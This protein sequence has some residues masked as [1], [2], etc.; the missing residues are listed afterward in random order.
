MRTPADLA[1]RFRAQGLK[2]TPQRELLFKLVYGNQTH[3][4]AEVIYAE[5]RQVMPTM[6]LK[7]VYQTLNDLTEMGELLQLDFGTG[8]SR[9]DPNIGDHHHLVCTSCGKVRDLS[10]TFAD[11]DV[12]PGDRQGFEVEE[13]EVVFRG[14][15]AAC[16]STAVPTS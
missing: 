1:K 11:L 13:A 5:A 2:V 10:A 6:S 14:V 15:C 16:R 3:P 12:P 9:F 8:S 4:T 7:T